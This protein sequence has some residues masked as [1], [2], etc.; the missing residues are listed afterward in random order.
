[1]KSRNNRSKVLTISAL[2][3][4]FATASTA[5]GK[6]TS[7]DAV[8]R[9]SLFTVDC[10][11]P[12]GFCASGTING[13]HGLRGTSSFSALSF[14]PIP[15]DPSGRLAVPGI[16]TYA[17]DSGTLTISDVSVFDVER[18]TFAGVGR[19]TQGTGSF[20]GATGDIF[21][22]GRVLADGESFTTDVSGAI[23]LPD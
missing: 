6:C 11:S 20:A 2:I 12:V 1:M 4:I 23:C 18:G 5:Q 13:K 10:T 15:G 7:L 22:L 8:R 19:I 21:T 9:D 3:A 17:T 14:D 16:S